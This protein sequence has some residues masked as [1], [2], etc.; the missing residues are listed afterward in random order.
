MMTKVALG[1]AVAKS[2]TLY[3]KHEV[4]TSRTGV[5][6]Q[7]ANAWLVVVGISGLLFSPTR[8]II[9]GNL[10]DDITVVSGVDILKLGH[11]DD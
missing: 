9:Y 7:T 5:V 4:A 1:D 6:T 3:C 10:E 8:A 11:A 2:E